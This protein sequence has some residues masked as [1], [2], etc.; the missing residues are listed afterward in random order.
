MSQDEHTESRTCALSQCPA[1]IQAVVRDTYQD[2]P[3]RLKVGDR[4]MAYVEA[5][6]TTET[7]E[8]VAP[9]TTLNQVRVRL[10]DIVPELSGV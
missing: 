8:V 2:D 6:N 7:W 9:G 5:S 10:L 1:E 4:L 3:S